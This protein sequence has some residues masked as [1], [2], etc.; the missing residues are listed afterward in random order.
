MGRIDVNADYP[1]NKPSVNTKS[2]GSHLC[3]KKGYWYILRI[4]IYYKN[5]RIFKSYNF[6]ADVLEKVKVVRDTM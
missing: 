2:L 5:S 4:S 6:L 3:Y 1:I